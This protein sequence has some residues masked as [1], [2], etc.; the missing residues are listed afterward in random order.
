MGSQTPEEEEQGN[1][2]QDWLLRGRDVFFLFPAPPPCLAF[3]PSPVNEEES[4]EMESILGLHSVLQFLSF[5]RSLLALKL[6]RPYSLKLP[7]RS[8]LMPFLDELG[9]P[10]SS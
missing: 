9:N 4:R 2:S 1:L 3:A 10:L 6:V 7:S 5:T 8:T